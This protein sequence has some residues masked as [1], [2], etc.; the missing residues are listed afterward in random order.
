MDGPLPAHPPAASERVP[1]PPPPH[2]RNKARQTAHWPWLCRAADLCLF[3]VCSVT[4]FE[5]VQQTVALC[6]MQGTCSGLRRCMG[7][8]SRHAPSGLSD[9]RGFPVPLSLPLGPPLKMTNTGFPPYSEAV[10]RTPWR[11][12]T[13]GRASRSS[14]RLAPH[15]GRAPFNNSAPFPPS[16]PPPPPKDRAKSPRREVVR[17]SAGASVVYP[18]FLGSFA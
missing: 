10:K 13:E 6:T 12:G 5:A 17:S 16:S 9:F 1:P 18:P 2:K 14:P 8:A 4:P 3:F 15:T 11:R 7:R